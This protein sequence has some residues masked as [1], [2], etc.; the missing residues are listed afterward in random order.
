ML[1]ED[2][3]ALV[4]EIVPRTLRSLFVLRI[5]LCGVAAL[6]AV[7]KI[8]LS[9]PTSEFLIFLISNDADSH[10]I[11]TDWDHTLN[12]L[13]SGLLA[14][15]LALVIATF[16]IQ[17]RIRNQAEQELNIDAPGRTTAQP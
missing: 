10:R 3:L 12:L 9:P 14:A 5:S 2:Q 11:L 17:A 8:M 4:N 7:V 13:F 1:T 16:F 6:L 15:V